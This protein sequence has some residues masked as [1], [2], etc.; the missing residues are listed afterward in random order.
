VHTPHLA[1]RKRK[2]V[3][4]TEK[5]DLA[6][7]HDLLAHLR[8]YRQRRHTRVVSP[9]SVGMLQPNETLEGISLLADQHRVHAGRGQRLR[10][11]AP[12]SVEQV[13]LAT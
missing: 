9:V 1:P 5:L 3:E 4:A 10:G 13:A 2:T 6:G 8:S 12:E 7:G 11:H